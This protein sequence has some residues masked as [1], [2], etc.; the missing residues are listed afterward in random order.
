MWGLKFF[1]E[2]AARTAH[3]AVLQKLADY[4]FLTMV[5]VIVAWEFGTGR[6]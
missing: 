2:N 6:G 1:Q 5:V 4:C 3:H